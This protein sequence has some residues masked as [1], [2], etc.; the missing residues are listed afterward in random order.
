MKN[1]KN[2]ESRI[3]HGWLI[4]AALLLPFSYFIFPS[5]ALADGT[6]CLCRSAA[7]TCTNYRANSVVPGGSAGDVMTDAQCSAFCEARGTGSDD[8]HIG[9]AYSGVVSACSTQ[10]LEGGSCTTASGAPGIPTLNTCIANS[11]I[12]RDVESLQRCCELGRRDGATPEN[13]TYSGTSQACAAD[14]P[15][16][17]P[18][19]STTGPI[20]LYNPLGADTDIPAFIGRGIRGVLGV[21]GAIALLMFVYGGVVWMTAGDSKR[22]DDAKNII[23]NSVIGLLLIFFSYNL[24]GIFFDFFT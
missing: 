18:A 10:C 17:G 6:Y 1:I 22:V 19:V 24:I 7:F 20:R 9:S 4:V 8:I 15:A 11:T 14:A 16:G 5:A 3:Q 2:R 13:V 12:Y 23:K 21:I